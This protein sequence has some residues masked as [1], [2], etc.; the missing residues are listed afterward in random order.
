VEH[1]GF[2]GTG[3]VANDDV[4]H[5]VAAESADRIKVR[6]HHGDANTL[7]AADFKEV[8]RVKCFHQLP[9]EMRSRVHQGYGTAVALRRIEINSSRCPVD[10]LAE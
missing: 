9:V 6:H 10:R 1:S 3:W 2:R 7:R 4:L 5:L 8:G